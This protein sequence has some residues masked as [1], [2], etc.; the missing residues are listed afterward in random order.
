MDE[1]YRMFTSRSEYRLHLRSDNADLRLM[2]HGRRI[3]LIGDDSFAAF[4][5]YEKLVENNLEHLEKTRDE[6]TH[7]PLAK[8]LRQGEHLPM[9]W[10]INTPSHPNPLP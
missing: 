7:E 8:R 6:S 10:L 5:R 9:E 1:P 2:A 3:G 4:E